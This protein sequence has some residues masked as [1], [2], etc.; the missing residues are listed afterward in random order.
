MWPW[1]GEFGINHDDYIRG[2]TMKTIRTQK[3]GSQEI[4]TGFDELQ[5]D[6][7]ASRA[8]AKEELLKTEIHKK[9]MLSLREAA[10]RKKEIG[11][12]LNEA[13]RKI[14]ALDKKYNLLDYP[15]Q[16]RVS[17]LSTENPEAVEEYLSALKDHVAARKSATFSM[18]A[19]TQGLESIIKK[20]NDEHRRQLEINTVY[21]EPR[22]GE[23]VPTESQMSKIKKAAET[24]KDTELLTAAGEKIQKPEKEE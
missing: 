1:T 5:I 23:I 10:E 6:P 9:Y 12:K 22:L 8:K 19:V 13:M 18:Q 21:F 7:Q 20:V 2:A 15:E 14:H 17:V 24:L 3:L 11:D 16:I 4:I